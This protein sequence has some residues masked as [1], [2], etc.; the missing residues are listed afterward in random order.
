MKKPK[1]EIFEDKSGKF[2]FRLK[3]ANGEPIMTGREYDSKPGVV[4]AIANVMIEA[5]TKNAATSRFVRKSSVSGKHYFQLRSKG[6]RLIGWSELY[7][8]KQ[9]RDIGIKA[10]ITAC[11]YA[12]IN[13]LGK[14]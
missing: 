4:E 14:L 8:S 6:G 10:V 11:Q 2:Y 12:N 9:G 5:T 3:A 1:F 7:E 13:D